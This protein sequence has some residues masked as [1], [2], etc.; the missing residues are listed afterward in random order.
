MTAKRFTKGYHTIRD[1]YENKTYDFRVD[2]ICGLL[3]ELDEKW[4]DEFNLRETLQLELQRV[5]EE[6]EQLKQDNA[7]L[8]KL[9]ENQS[10]I[11]QKLHS[12]ILEFG[13][14]E[15]IVLTKEDLEL[16]DKA[17]SYYTHGRY[18]E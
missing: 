16:M 15:P 11:I 17:I 5:E 3:N 2:I 4:I 13:L 1:T 9:L 18:G 7:G 8:M 6:N 10:I 12:K 14:R